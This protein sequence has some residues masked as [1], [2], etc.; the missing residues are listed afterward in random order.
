MFFLCWAFSSQGMMSVDPTK[1]LFGGKTLREAKKR[2]PLVLQSI[3]EIGEHRKVVINGK[4]LKLG[5]KISSYKV[6][7]ITSKA[8]VLNSAQQ[9]LELSLFSSAVTK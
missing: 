7:A 9:R 1:P 6:T 3:I 4:M 5:D 2:T 8:V